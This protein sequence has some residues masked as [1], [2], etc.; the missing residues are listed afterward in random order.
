MNGDYILALLIIFFIMLGVLIPII[1]ESFN[2]D[3]DEN[4]INTVAEGLTGKGDDSVSA[5]DIIISI[6]SMF[7]WSFGAIVWWVDLLLLVPL[8][9]IAL[10]LLAVRINQ[11]TPF[12]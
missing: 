7:F 4:N 2:L 11:A 10:V 1:Q 3:K 12:T 6:V 8:R 9:I 5:F